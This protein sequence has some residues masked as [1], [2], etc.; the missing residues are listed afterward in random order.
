M[1]THVDYKER[2]LQ[3]KCFEKANELETI[4][5]TMFI[6]W[7]KILSTNLVGR[8]RKR[9]EVF[10]NIALHFIHMMPRNEGAEPFDVGMQFKLM[11]GG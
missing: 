8:E 4:L 7:K 2:M 6:V 3:H 10:N 5:K 9:G 11:G 1:N